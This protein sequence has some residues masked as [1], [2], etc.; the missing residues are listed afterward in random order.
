MTLRQAQDEALRRAQGENELAEAVAA[1][2][3]AAETLDGM[4]VAFARVRAEYMRAWSGTGV[5]DAA[6]REHYWVA[7]QVIDKVETH[8]QTA[9]TNGR[10]AARELERI[11]QLRQRKTRVW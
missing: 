9:A 11:T 8:L 1:G 10:V 2:D 3:R 7:M 6:V 5:Q 4:R